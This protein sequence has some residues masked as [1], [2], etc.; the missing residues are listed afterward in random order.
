MEA[1]VECKSKRRCR[2][3]ERVA[4]YG[5]G[6]RTVRHG[7]AVAHLGATQLTLHRNDDERLSPLL[8]PQPF[9]GGIGLI[10]RPRDTQSASL[11]RE[12]T[13]RMHVPFRPQTAE[14]ESSRKSGDFAMMRTLKCCRF[15][16]KL[17]PI[18]VL[19]VVGGAVSV[20]IVTS[21]YPSLP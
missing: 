9:A 8:G 5:T 17:S 18:Q 6:F 13:R 11:S 1:R 20:G 10:M 4:R 7:D 3:H 21:R 2:K 19:I 12:T 15:S 16:D 14:W